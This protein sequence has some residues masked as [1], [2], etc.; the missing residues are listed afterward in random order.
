LY[1][2]ELLVADCGTQLWT[3]DTR[4]TSS[5]LYAYK[6]TK[7]GLKKALLNLFSGLSGKVTSISTSSSTG[8]SVAGSLD[9][10]FR[11]LSSGSPSEGS[12]GVVGKFYVTSAPTAIVPIEI[13]GRALASDEEEKLDE[14]VDERDDDWG[15]IQQVSS[16][17]ENISQARKKRRKRD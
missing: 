7:T 2:S 6:G 15:E 3:I 5:P 14:E 8:F 17:E 9:R 12:G 4:K 13:A 11:L 16:D 10:Y 1:L